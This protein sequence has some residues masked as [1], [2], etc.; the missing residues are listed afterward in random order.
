[1]LP[2]QYLP[3]LPSMNFP[4]PPLRPEAS[5]S[6]AANE[7]PSRTLLRTASSHRSSISIND[8]PNILHDPSDTKPDPYANSD[9]GMKRQRTRTRYTRSTRGCFTCRS[10][11]VK[12]D[13]TLPTCLRCQMNR[14][15]C[16]WPDPEQLAHPRKS[17]KKN[18]HGVHKINNNGDRDSV[19]STPQPQSR[20]GSVSILGFRNGSST[21]ISMTGTA[22]PTPIPIPIPTPLRVPL[23]QSRDL[24][25]EVDKDWREISIPALGNNDNNNGERDRSVSF[26]M[27]GD[28]FPVSPVDLQYLL[29]FTYR[30]CTRVKADYSCIYRFIPVPMG[31]DLD[32]QIAPFT[33]NPAPSDPLFSSGIGLGIP[34]SSRLSAQPNPNFPP[35]ANSN[36]NPIVTP[37]N[38]P[39]TP[40]DLT[41]PRINTSSSSS[42]DYQPR[43]QQ[44]D[45]LPTPSL[46][47]SVLANR[48]MTKGKH[49][50]VSEAVGGEG[51][52]GGG[53]RGY[54]CG[55]GYGQPQGQGQG[56]G[57]GDEISD[58]FLHGISIESLIK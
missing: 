30:A 29:V 1:M 8:S 34:S 17:R 50:A 7:S 41:L 10:A 32:I 14:R 12:C 23:S 48:R 45:P 13:E 35:N 43:Q 21:S 28:L 56:Y 22:T 54:G 33:N 2:N 44:A 6:S 46:S 16:E 25:L 26:S 4:G 24:D 20:A 15:E 53:D 37:T 27:E 47:N 42:C 51:V 40:V 52:A 55:C 9:A 57:Y 38:M 3:R 31:S 5:S 18:N 39:I 36:S 19:A 49:P 11:K 58:G